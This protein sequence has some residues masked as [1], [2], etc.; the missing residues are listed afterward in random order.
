MAW[1]GGTLLG[2]HPYIALVAPN[3]DP[4]PLKWL[5]YWHYY[6]WPCLGTS[7]PPPQYYYSWPC[8]GTCQSPPPSLEDAYKRVKPTKRNRLHTRVLHKFHFTCFCILWLRHQRENMWIKLEASS[9]CM[10][11]FPF[12]HVHHVNSDL[13]R[14]SK[15]FRC[16]SSHSKIQI[17]YN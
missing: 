8:L 11:N 2:K 7:Q 1:R 12:L 14:Q 6:S 5:T 4:L 17:D 16:R 13:F 10:G 9:W 3:I 15:M